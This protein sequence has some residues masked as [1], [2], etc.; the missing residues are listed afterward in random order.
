M[1]FFLFVHLVLEPCKTVLL[2]A[3][4]LALL[5]LQGFYWDITQCE[6]FFLQ[7]WM[8]SSEPL[9]CLL[10]VYLFLLYLMFCFL[11]VEFS[12]LTYLLYPPYLWYF[13]P[14]LWLCIQVLFF[15]FIFLKKN[16]VFNHSLHTWIYWIAVLV[17]VTL[18]KDLCQDFITWSWFGR[19]SQG[20]LVE[21]W[22]SKMIRWRKPFD[23]LFQ[24]S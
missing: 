22:G 14:S 6:S 15:A 18:E 3:C 11:C 5:K 24:T 7:S 1:I 19:R 8:D 10:F 20:T 13:F 9:K 17:W 2:W 21:E 16:S 12:L 4:L 23:V